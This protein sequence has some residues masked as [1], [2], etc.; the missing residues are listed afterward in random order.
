MNRTPNDRLDQALSEFLDSGSDDDSETLRAFGPA[1]L[2]RVLDL[3]YRGAESRAAHIWPPPRAQGREAV[4]AW[5]SA[6]AALGHAFPD[7]YLDAIEGGS[8]VSPTSLGEVTVVAGIPGP[9]AVAFLARHAGD[10]DHLIRYHAVRALGSRDDEMAI[11]I[12]EER[13]SDPNALV[14]LAAIRGL[15]WRDPRPRKTLLASAATDTSFPPLLRDEAR[16]I[17]RSSP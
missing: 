16:E 8:L 14:R 7:R 17:L 9:R 13:L 1:P 5:S 12:V 2:D 3:C 10:A 4:D 15:I 6:L 11:G